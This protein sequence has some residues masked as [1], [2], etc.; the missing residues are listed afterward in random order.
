MKDIIYVPAEKKLNLIFEYLDY[1]FKKY[2][3]EHRDTMTSMQI[4]VFFLF[5]SL[6]NSNFYDFEVKIT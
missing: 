6:N 1:D 5:L 4:K 3:N 2:M